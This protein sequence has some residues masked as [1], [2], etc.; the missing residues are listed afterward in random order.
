MVNLLTGI[1]QLFLEPEWALSQ[2]PKR[3]KA[4][5]AIDSE[6]MRGRG[7]NVSVKSNQLIKN[8]ENKKHFSY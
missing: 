1:K 4:E 3:P 6:A 7:I 8:I 5:L 2:S